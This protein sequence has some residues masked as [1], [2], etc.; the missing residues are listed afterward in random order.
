M[1][2]EQRR[3]L[4]RATKA[5]ARKSGDP[6]MLKGGPMDGYYVTKDAPALKAAWGV[7]HGGRYEVQDKTDRDGLVWAR[8]K[9]EIP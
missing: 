1:N 6:V 9:E 5:N 4:Q 8:W 7:P 3:K 2:R